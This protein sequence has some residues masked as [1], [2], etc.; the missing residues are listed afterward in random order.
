VGAEDRADP[1]VRARQVDLVVPEEPAE[2]VVRG[3]ARP[4]P[5]LQ[6]RRQRKMRERETSNWRLDTL[7]WNR[8]SGADRTAPLVFCSR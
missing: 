7:V 1:E 5:L 6:N 3:E 2:P 8:T 4:Q